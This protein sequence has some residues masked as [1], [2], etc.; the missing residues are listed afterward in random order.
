MKIFFNDFYNGK[1]WELTKAIVNGYYR[2][3]DKFLMVD[4][5]QAIKSSDDIWQLVNIRD[6]AE[7]LAG[8]KYKFEEWE[9]TL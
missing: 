1:A 8:K 4:E 6:L 9:K 3:A 5:N 2:L 7:Y